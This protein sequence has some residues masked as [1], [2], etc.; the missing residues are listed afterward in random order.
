MA[1]AIKPEQLRAVALNAQEYRAIVQALG[2]DPNDLELGIFGA[3]GS[4]H[5]AT[6]TSKPLRRQ[7]PT[8]GPHA[9][10]GPA[11]TAAPVAVAD[12]RARVSKLDT[13]NHP[14][15]TNR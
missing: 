10:R 1:V 9:L 13:H 2:R 4:H 7:L 12:R 14:P 5:G 11:E 3:L 15:P 6:K 8:E